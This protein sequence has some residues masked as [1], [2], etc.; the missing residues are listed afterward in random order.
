MVSCHFPWSPAAPVFLVHYDPPYTSDLF[1]AP[2]WGLWSGLQ[3]STHEARGTVEIDPL[4]PPL[5]NVTCYHSLHAL[6]LPLHH[7]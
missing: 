1:E 7:V 5:L 3:P 2:P 4:Q 6:A